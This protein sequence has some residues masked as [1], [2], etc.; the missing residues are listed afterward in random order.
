MKCRSILIALLVSLQ[1]VHAE[2]ERYAFVTMYYPGAHQSHSDMIAIRTLYKSFLAVK[3]KAEFLVIS[4]PDISQKDKLVFN[5]DGI[6][7]RT[8][9]LQNAYKHYQIIPDYQKTKNLEF[10]WKLKD[11]K[12]VI[13]VDPYTIFT[14]NFDSLFDCSYLCL[15][16][17]QPL[18]LVFFQ[19]HS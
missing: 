7:L 17:E 12:R 4:S 16:D 3:S 1:C 8:M 5:N 11:Y 18:V 10:L 19:S 14:H 13:F 9:S 15:K 2:N 6:Q